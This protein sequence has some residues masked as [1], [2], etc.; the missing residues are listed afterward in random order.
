M[1]KQTVLLVVDKTA[2]VTCLNGWIRAAQEQDLHLSV[3]VV[4]V[5]RPIPTTAFGGIPY[6]GIVVTEEWQSGIKLDAEKLSA[7]VQE[8][9]NAVSQAGISANVYGSHSE[10]PLM[11]DDIEL[12]VGV[13]DLAAIPDGHALESATLERAIS[14]LIFQSPVA[15]AIHSTDPVAVLKPKKVFVAWKPGLPAARAI[16]AALPQLQGADE[17]IVAIFDPDMRASKD[18]EDPCADV[19]TW[20]SR[21]GCK[22]TVQQL[23]S[24]GRSIGECIN[25]HAKQAGAD[26]IVMGAYGHSK[27]RERI[28]GGT[29][30]MILDEAST[31]VLLAH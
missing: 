17:V 6:G 8:I 30:H 2:P 16:H 9:E 23:A 14:A 28:F 27:L 7:K 31:P 13:S 22:V 26:L 18:G 1:P 11:A 12:T 4:A 5:A 20:L 10:L 25:A 29:T 21:Q 3:L 19:A 24:G 15:V